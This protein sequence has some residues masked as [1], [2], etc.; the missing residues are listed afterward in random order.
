MAAVKAAMEE[1][2][3]TDL[4]TYKDVP[5]GHAFKVILADE[6]KVGVI[7]D[8]AILAAGRT[9]DGKVGYVRVTA[10][11]LAEFTE[12]MAANLTDK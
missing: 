12:V 3:L 9:T 2:K 7:H 11:E 1:R 5:S 10:K 4:V 6:H 8:G